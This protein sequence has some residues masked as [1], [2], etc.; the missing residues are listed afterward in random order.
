MRPEASYNA[1]MKTVRMIGLLLIVGLA[2]GHDILGILSL[3]SE[4]LRDA[5]PEGI[6]VF[7]M[8]DVLAF[9]VVLTASMIG[10]IRRT[11]RV[12][13]SKPV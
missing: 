13:L 7:I 8:L 11:R 10:E 4:K 12:T 1:E 9:V 2:F 3:F 5:A 6:Y